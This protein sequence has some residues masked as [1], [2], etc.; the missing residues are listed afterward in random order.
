MTFNPFDHPI[1]W[2][3]SGAPAESSEGKH[4]AFGRLLV[5][6]LRPR[7]LV[8]VGS[9]SGTFYLGLIA[10]V[11]KLA[12]EARCFCFPAPGVSEQGMRQSNQTLAQSPTSIVAPLVS[13]S[14]DRLGDMPID[15]LSCH[16]GM[17]AGARGS[18]GSGVRILQSWLERASSRAVVLVHDSVQSPFST[19]WRE[20]IEV[21]VESHQAIEFP[22]GDG[23]TCLILG[24]EAN[25][26]LQELLNL[27]RENQVFVR[28]FFKDLGELETSGDAASDRPDRDEIE[29]RLREI[30]QSSA[31]R[32]IGRYRLAVERQLPYGSRRRA[33]YGRAVSQLRARLPIPAEP[34]HSSS[35]DRYKAPKLVTTL[36]PLRFP[37]ADAPRVSVVITTF[38]QPV[39]TYNAIRSLIRSAHEVPTELIV[40]DDASTDETST[41]L[42]TIDGIRTITN[43]INLGFTRSC[44]VGLGLAIGE[45]V[46]F[47]NNDALIRGEALAAMLELMDRDARIGAVGAKLLFPDGSLQEAGAIVWSDAT[48]WNYGRFDD[49]SRPQYN[50]VR[51]VDYCSGACLLVRREAMERVGGLDSKYAPAYYEDVDLAFSLR[52][53]GY[54]MMYQPF[55][56][57]THYEGISSGTDPSKGVKRFQEVNR[58]KFKAKWKDELAAHFPSTASPH[59]AKDR[60][61]KSAVLVADDQV[62]TPD[63]DAGSLRMFHL[64]QLLA[65]S[66]RKIAFV[67]SG[68][69]P[70]STYSIAVQQLG[71]EILDSKVDL[72][73]YLKGIA[74]R[75]ETVIL[76]RP[77]V[78]RRL[79]PLVRR[80][81]PSARILYDTVDLHFVRMKREAQITGSWGA[82][83]RAK[84]MQRLE[85]RLATASDGVIVVN[86][87]EKRSLQQLVGSLPIYVVAT[88]HPTV[89]YTKPFR[90]REGLIFVGNFRHTPNA[91]AIVHFVQEI[92]PVIRRA[93][94]AIT[95]RIIGGNVTSDVAALASDYVKVMG[96]VPDLEPHLRDSRLF[97]APLR[98]GAGLKGKVGHALAAGLPGVLSSVAAE[99]FEF[100]AAHELLVADDPARFAQAV[101]D[102]YTDEALWTS[103]RDAGSIAVQSL[104]SREVVSTALEE[105]VTG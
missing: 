82:H 65:E 81:A 4:L 34:H 56:E 15:L 36:E 68:M 22:H 63:Q 12:L 2:A 64:L 104:C 21:L 77:L 16:P 80:C 38:N 72:P 39:F 8:D 93:L 91:D 19:S 94:P 41:V 52:A 58:H 31:W 60:L 30:E 24:D 11:E 23:L 70:N 71:V 57:V 45:Y 66:G 37:A 55:A 97:V 103:A 26:S 47:L 84:K 10:A 18:A 98:F 27:Y 61:F 28:G 87:V 78:A 86:P 33:L 13:G 88:L 51:P 43:S 49:A 17:L 32:A 9:L 75:L 102:L 79:L 42:Q 46:L 3:R 25:D 92:L 44:N 62:P 1:L 89:I 6:L 74:S 40:V 105:A 90:D 53:L 73:T 35:R 95:L 69:D 76:S 50:Y 29:R 83:L 7:A 54:R 100:A 48:A 67:P 5:D 85:S 59:I 96:W 101:V 20:V 99:G 14:T